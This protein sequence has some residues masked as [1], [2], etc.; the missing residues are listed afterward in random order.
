[1]TKGKPW[2]AD[3]EKNLKA[4]FTS[5]TTDFRVLAFSLDGRYTE[6]AIR[7]KLIKLGLMKEQQQSAANCC[8]SSN[9]ELPE[10]M[11]S[12]EEAL[13][14]LCAALKAL[15]APGLDKSEVLRLRS[16][17]SGIK[18]YKELF[19]DYLDYRG[20]EQRLIDLEGKYG[21]L[22]KGKKS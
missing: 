14:I 16:I 20:L 1:M 11:P 8:C 7:Q 5:G 9:L 13:K 12:V 18:T 17:I 15:E 4:W 10:E 6:E 22:G 21:A 3:D 19:V 2:P